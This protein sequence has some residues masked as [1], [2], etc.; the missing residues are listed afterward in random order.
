[1]DDARLYKKVHYYKPQMR[2]K[3]MKECQNVS[4]SPEEEE[5]R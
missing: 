1:M 5:N 3:M 2:I 4:K